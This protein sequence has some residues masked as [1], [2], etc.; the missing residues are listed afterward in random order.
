MGLGSLGGSVARK[1][2]SFGFQV[3]GYSRSPKS[4]EGVQCYSGIDNANL[5]LDGVHVL[6]NLLP[7]TPQTSG[8][9]NSQTFSRL[10]R[11]AYI[12]NLA[13]GAHLVE[14]DLVAALRDG[15]IAGATLD[16]FKCEPLMDDHPFWKDSRITI[17]PHISA[18]TRLEESVA[19]IAEKIDEVERGRVP[20]GRVDLLHGY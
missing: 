1:I 8:V 17:T 11:G 3:R 14:D 7:N 18:Q 12:V 9:L 15:Q 16:V 2:A 20:S 13:R 4:I 6:V 5:F 10:V 19:Q